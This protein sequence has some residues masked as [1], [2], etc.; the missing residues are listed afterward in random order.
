MPEGGSSAGIALDRN[1]GATCIWI[2]KEFRLWHVSNGMLI[3]LGE[4]T[5]VLWFAKGAAASRAEVKHSIDTGFPILEGM[6]R[7]DGPA[8][9][10][11][12][13]RMMGRIARYMPAS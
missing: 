12:L 10:S 6:A 1:P 13:H 2:T 4:P 5:N 3:R 9:V 7:K 8:A 11:E